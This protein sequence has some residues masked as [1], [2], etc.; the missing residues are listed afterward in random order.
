MNRPAETN[1][2]RVVFSFRMTIQVSKFLRDPVDGGWLGR[3]TI[4]CSN[5][6]AQL[7]QCILK[8]DL[9]YIDAHMF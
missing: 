1:S 6:A 7:V 8:M 3:A 2:N 5:R 4:S 9:V